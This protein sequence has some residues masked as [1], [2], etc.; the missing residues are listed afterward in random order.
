MKAFEALY[1]AIDGTMSTN[2]K[3]SAMVDYFMKSSP[4]DAAWAVFFLSGRR[5]KRFLSSRILTLWFLE[6]SGV[7]EW[8]FSEC[9]ESVGDTAETIALL[10]DSLGLNQSDKALHVKQSKLLEVSEDKDSLA[11]WIED[12][13]LWLEKQP[14]VVQKENVAGWW[15]MLGT[16][17]IFIVNKLLTGAFRVGVSQKLL[18][19]AIA[20]VA[21]L[22]PSVIAHRMMGHWQPTAAFYQKLTAQ[23]YSES[24]ISRPYPFFLASPIETTVEENVESL[25]KTLGPVSAWQIEWKWDGIRAQ[26]IHRQGKES[27]EVFIWSRGEDLL[28][29]RFPELE[30]IAAKLPIGTVLDGE[31]L[32]HDASAPLP[33]SVLQTRIGRKNVTQ[34]LKRE[35]PVVFMA[36]DLLEYNGRDIRQ[37]PLSERRSLLSEI[38][39]AAGFPFIISEVVPAAGWEEAKTLRQEARD[40]QVEGFILKRLFSTYQS[41]RKRG[42]WWKWKV[43]PFTVDAVLLYAQAGT[44][45][46]ANLFTDYTFAVWE[47]DNLVPVAKAYSGL[48]NDEIAQLDKWIRANTKEKFGP[49]RSLKA[50][51]VFELAFEGIAE[52]KRHKSGVALRFPRILRWRTDKPVAEADTLDSLK[53]LIQENAVLKKSSQLIV[54]G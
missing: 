39:R 32:A 19:R 22:E 14:E 51:H 12:K 47:G 25:E 41:G 48:S 4:Q 45:R 3:V 35:A 42:D 6:I 24:D 53:K 27:S 37:E 1:E 43:D 50:H 20:E 9:Y 40:R 10:A 13:I 34:K 11:S 46:R 18:V 16:S 7:E 26:C 8:L 44:G 54:G 5:L 23:D 52:S 21:G 30:E 31:I 29:G 36:Y 2:G 49:V 15:K 17:E 28:S 33:F 38:I